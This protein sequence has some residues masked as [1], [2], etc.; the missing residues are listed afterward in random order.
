MLDLHVSFFPYSRF[1][2][3]II[4]LSSITLTIFSPTPI[5]ASSNDFPPTHTDQE[6]LASYLSRINEDTTLSEAISFLRDLREC[7]ID[8]GYDIPSLEDLC[9]GMRD[10]LMQQGI[11][12][13][14]EEVE[15]LYEEILRQE[16]SAE[17]SFRAAINTNTKYNLDYVKS[18]KKKEGKETKV[19][20]KTMFGF[21]K[22]IV[23]G[24]ICIVPF[25]PVQAAG[26]GLIM[27]GIND[28]IDGAR[29][30]GDENEQLQQMDEQRR[31]EAMEGI[32][33]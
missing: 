32:T 28:C 12:I 14:D 7:L 24:L 23:G 4:F 9:S 1:I 17:P 27:S 18:S 21:I 13:D 31:R 20:S 33:P 2:N 8:Q 6:W 3:K 29:E 19:K 5:L 15:E 16:N 26:A 11:F 22:C 30:Q 10:Y 25:P